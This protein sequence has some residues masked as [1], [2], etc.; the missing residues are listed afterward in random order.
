MQLRFVEGNQKRLGNIKLP[1]AITQGIRRFFATSNALRPDGTWR[2]WGANHQ[3]RPESFHEPGSIDELVAI[4]DSA[5]ARSKKIRIVGAGHSW[6]DIVCTDEWMV[7]L[8]RINELIELDR[9]NKTVTV[10]A[11]MRVAD[12]IDHLDAAGLALVNL[13][14]VDAQHVGGV[15]ATA[16][17]GSGSTGSFSS[18]VLSAKLLLSSGKVIEI[19]SAHNA[20]YLDA[21][22]TNLGCLGIVVEATLAVRESFNVLKHQK[23]FG[24]EAAIAN[25]AR[26]LS[27][28][29]PYAMNKVFFF[30]YGRQHIYAAKREDLSEP[31][32][33]DRL[34]NPLLAVGDRLTLS[35][36]MNAARQVPID[37]KPRF[38]TAALAAVSTSS[39]Q[40]GKSYDLL[41]FAHDP[42]F[43]VVAGHIES[44]I[45]IPLE[46]LGPAVTSLFE[47][48][49]RRTFKINGYILARTVTKETAWMSPAHGRDSVFLTFAH[50]PS[51]AED[52]K[53]IFAEIEAFMI[54]RHQG[55]PHWGKINFTNREYAERAYPRYVDFAD[56]RRELDPIGMFANDFIRRH[57]A[58]AREAVPMSARPAPA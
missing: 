23:I 47:L 6:S 31:S 14:E 32:L 18:A 15:I 4:V 49:E 13:G 28:S 1:S 25:A 24:T 16:T 9:K 5:R 45:A 40:V 53:A 10:Q 57:F 56:V 17:H 34:R 51:E 43:K 33:W 29:D 36:L 26:F 42:R 38:L 11:G 41:L 50:F 37:L 12:L 58:V 27:L 20:Q 8:A 2:N 21:V 19:S 44:E 3:C 55:R 39:Y 46:G 54:E 48:M 22:R 30:P 7:S 35:V 52:W